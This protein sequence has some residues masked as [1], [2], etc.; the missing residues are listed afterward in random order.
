MLSNHTRIPPQTMNSPHM[1]LTRKLCWLIVIA[2]SNEKTEK[3]W[4]KTRLLQIGYALR[5][6]IDREGIAG[7]LQSASSVLRQQPS[8]LNPCRN[9]W[10]LYVLTKEQGKETWALPI[11]NLRRLLTTIWQRKAVW[12]TLFQNKSSGTINPVYLPQTTPEQ[13]EECV[14]QQNTVCH[15]CYPSFLSC[16]FGGT[17]H[18]Q[19]WSQS[20][21]VLEN[22]HW[23]E[24]HQ[25]LYFGLGVGCY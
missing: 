8:K 22:V 12:K 19:L 4:G 21:S 18:E 5:Q 25:F 11:K 3:P 16:Y 9:V 2:L 7:Q 1:L 24:M 17:S 20:Y 15:K 10:Y 13:Y 14:N 6:R 23:K